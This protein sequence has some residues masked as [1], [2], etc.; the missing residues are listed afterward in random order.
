M[1]SRFVAYLL[2]WLLLMEAGFI[3]L[4]LMSAAIARTS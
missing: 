4:P 1:N 2:G 3:C